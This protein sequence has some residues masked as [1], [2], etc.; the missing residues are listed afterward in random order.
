MQT[1]LERGFTEILTFTPCDLLS[2]LKGRTLFFSGDSQTQ[3]CAWQGSRLG[4]LG[5][6]Q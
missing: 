6:R 2:L 3:A 4:F 5:F 1:Y